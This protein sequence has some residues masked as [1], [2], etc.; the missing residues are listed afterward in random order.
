[1]DRSSETDIRRI[2]RQEFLQDATK[3]VR[4]AAQAPV[5]VC[6]DQG[7]PRMIISFPVITD[8]DEFGEPR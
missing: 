4:E 3:V 2:S 6:D 8:E 7:A 1:M 5:M